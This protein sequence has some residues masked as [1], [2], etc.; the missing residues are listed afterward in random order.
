MPPL[1]PPN[2]ICLGETVWDCFPEQKRLGGSPLNFAYICSQLGAVPSLVSSVGDDEE[3]HQALENVERLGLTSKFIQSHPTLRTGRAT[4]SH[5]LEGTP[6]FNL[7]PMSAW[8]ELSVSEET[9]SLSQSADA[10][11]FGS[12]CQRS[13]ASRFTIQNIIKTSPIKTLR[14]FDV[15]IRRPYFTQAVLR[16]SLHLANAL[17][18]SDE[19]LE[20]VAILLQLKGSAEDQLRI[21]RDN[22]GLDYIVLTCGPRGSYILHEEQFIHSPTD[23][24]KI[25]DTTGAGDAFAATFCTCILKGISL[26]QAAMH[27]NRVAAYVCTKLGATLQL[28]EEI[29]SPIPQPT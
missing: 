1:A 3:G 8:D 26:D 14:L 7:D 28:P 17:K 24:V 23:T 27:A 15:N 11:F 21:L 18:I 19:E 22:Y 13:S 20:E 16:S 2:I 29:R 12:L 25:V 10:I 9:K 6:R 4:I 5:G